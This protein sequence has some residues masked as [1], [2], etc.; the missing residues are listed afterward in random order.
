MLIQKNRKK[1]TS[2]QFYFLI[3]CLI[4]QKKLLIYRTKDNEFDL[5]NSPTT[6]YN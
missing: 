5:N 1:Q 6:L 2:S 3:K 4:Q